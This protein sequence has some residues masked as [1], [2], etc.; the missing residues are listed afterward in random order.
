MVS[1]ANESGTY[2]SFIYAVF[3]GLVCAM[4]ALGSASTARADSVTY[5]Y[6]GSSFTNCNGSYPATCTEDQVTA[7]ITLTAPLAPNLS[8]YTVPTSDITSF[9]ISDGMS[10]VFNQSDMTPLVVWTDASGN[11]EYWAMGADVCTTVSGTTCTNFD[12]IFSEN[13]YN[14]LGTTLSSLVSGETAADYSLTDFPTSGGPP[15]IDYGAIDSSNCGSPLDDAY[16]TNSPGTWSVPE[17]P[18]SVLLVVGLLGLAT[19][20]SHRRIRRLA[21]Q[22]A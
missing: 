11:I 14:G 8:L 16:V 6:T 2:K 3:L 5:T 7:S 9:S 19:L 17:P 12:G 21:I 15:C 20:R 22:H 18:S 10:L 4:C 13:V 1:M